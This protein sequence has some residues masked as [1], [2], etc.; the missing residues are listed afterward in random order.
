MP[1]SE[2]SVQRSIRLSAR[3]SELLDDLVEATGETRNSLIEQLLAESL[4]TYRHPLITFRT[5]A[6]GRREPC[7]N[8]TRL[9]VRQVIG[10]LRDEGGSIADVADALGIPRSHAQ[11]ALSYYADFTHEVDADRQWVDRIGA[12]E[13]AR[14]EREQAA[15]A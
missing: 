2:P 10:Q 15:I 8:G 5:G 12:E 1:R 7:I 3:T 9:L 11:A 13:R 6:A 4:R 14:W